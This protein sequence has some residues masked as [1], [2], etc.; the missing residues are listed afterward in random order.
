MIDMR[1]ISASLLLVGLTGGAFAQQQQQQPA[2]TPPDRET[3]EKRLAET[4]TNSRLT[5]YYTIEGQQG[6]PKEDQYTLTKVEKREGDKWLFTAV[7]AFGKQPMAIPLEIPI[8][9]AGDTPVISVTDFGVPGM[10]TY[11]ARVMIYRDHYAGTWS[12]GTHGGH[13]WGRVQHVDP[14]AATQSSEP[15]KKQDK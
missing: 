2:A 9:W 13:L 6:P 4:L 7:I 14:K 8:L 15:A 12:G 5:G 11:T 1:W 3:L 10:G